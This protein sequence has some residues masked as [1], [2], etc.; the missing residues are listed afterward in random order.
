[1]EMDE[2]VLFADLSKQIALLIMDDD[3]FASQQTTTVSPVQ[4]SFFLS[5]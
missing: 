5:C 3:E 2:D 4:V 1:M